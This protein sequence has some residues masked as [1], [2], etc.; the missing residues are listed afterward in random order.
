[1]AA[2]GAMLVLSKEFGLSELLHYLGFVL[3]GMGVVTALINYAMMKRDKQFDW[4]WFGLAAIELAAGII[5]LAND[6]WAESTFVMMIGGWAMI[7]GAYLIFT[8]LRKSSKSSIVA[9]SGIVSLAF[10]AIILF[11]NLDATLLHNLVGLYA[12]IFGVFTIN[13]SLKVRSYKVKHTPTE[14]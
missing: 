5:I 9:L 6:N 12:V 11:G 8:G 10:G 13:I 2:L 3:A 1:M 14:S 4:R 7:M